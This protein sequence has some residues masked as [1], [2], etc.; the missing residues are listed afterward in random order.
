MDWVKNIVTK[1]E[2]ADITNFSFC[3]NVIK[4][5]LL[6]MHL[7]V[8]KGST[9]N[10]VKTFKSSNCFCSVCSMDCLSPFSASRSADNPAIWLVSDFSSSSFDSVVSLNYKKKVR[11]LLETIPQI[12]IQ[13]HFIWESATKLKQSLNSMLTYREVIAKLMQSLM[14]ISM[15]IWKFTI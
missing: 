14:K 3:H 2:I 7:Q 15:N 6:H 9:I 11:I 1:G 8:G 5:C 4:S 12:R 13:L 10:N